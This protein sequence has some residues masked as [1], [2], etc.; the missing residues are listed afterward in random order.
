MFRSVRHMLQK[1]SRINRTLTKD[2]VSTL[3]SVC[4]REKTSSNSVDE[5]KDRRKLI[6]GRRDGEQRESG[7]CRFV[8]N[9]GAAAA[10][11]IDNLTAID[12]CRD[13]FNK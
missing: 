1:K 11:T 2:R 10:P 7:L 13:I 8:S 4:D 3:T 12:P 5:H 9:K 6:E